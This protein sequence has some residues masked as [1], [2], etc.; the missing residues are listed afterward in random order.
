MNKALLIIGLPG[1]GK[2]H[3]AK[4]KY[5]PLGYVLIDDPKEKPNAEGKDIVI[6]DP[7]LCDEN[8][9][10][11]CISFLE[12]MGY[13]VE[14]IYFEN[15]EEKCKKLIALRNDGRVIETFKAFKYTI[16]TSVVPLKI[17]EAN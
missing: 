13:A 7:H 4:T 11:S 3:L 15:D 12:K 8:I 5:V 9:R 16:P 17:Y 1:S 2:T 10:K 14:C 6:T